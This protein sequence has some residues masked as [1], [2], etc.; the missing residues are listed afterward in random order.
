MVL[1]VVI[2]VVVVVISHSCHP[3]PCPCQRSCIFSS[4]LSS[5]AATCHH[6]HSDNDLKHSSLPGLTDKVFAERSSPEEWRKRGDE[7]YKLGLYRVAAKCYYKSGDT[8]KEKM[9]LAQQK[10]LDAAQLRHNPRKLRDEFLYAAEDFLECGLT[11]EAAK[12]LN[13][14]R[15]F[16]LAAQ[17]YEKMGKVSV[18]S[19]L[20]VFKQ[21]IV[22][23]NALCTFLCQCREEARLG[24]R[25][26]Q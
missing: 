13:N 12:C 15:E 9:S 16:L 4:L 26:A 11:A 17:L 20:S 23:K 10:A 1:V 24:N 21:P 18:Q 7:F 6:P 3:T 5:A 14:A 8:L 19:H 2:I 22:R 25:F